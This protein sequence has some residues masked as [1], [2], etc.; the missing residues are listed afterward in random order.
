MV[1]GL[2]HCGADVVITSRK[3][4]ACEALAAE[5][6][7][8]TG[9]AALPYSCDVTKW[10]QLDGLVEAS[11]QRFGHVDIL[12]NNA[13]MSPSRP[14][15]MDVT[16][17][18]WDLAMNLNLSGPFRL[19][20]LVGFRMAEGRGGTILNISSSGSLHGEVFYGP[21]AMAKSGLNTLTKVLAK[22]Y[23]PNVRANCI[24]CGPFKTEGTR[25]YESSP[26]SRWEMYPLKRAGEAK[27]VV[28]AALYFCSDASSYT[29]GAQ[30]VID[31][32]GRDHLPST[33]GPSH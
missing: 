32:G 27:E 30:L 22:A 17:E 7:E 5:I 1:R 6:E 2:A 13:G 12:I 25:N 24:L 20:T 29:T 31:G 18:I 33:F 9:R 16:R 8:T 15:L 26:S 10:D 23:A 14:T 19:S 4:E 28:G 21:Y 11:Y 3:L